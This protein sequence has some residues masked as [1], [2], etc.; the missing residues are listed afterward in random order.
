MLKLS[1]EI[2]TFHGAFDG[3]EGQEIARL[4]LDVAAW[5]DAQPSPI[6]T[7]HEGTLRDL[8]GNTCGKWELK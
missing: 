2:K 7:K 3:R 8:N 1:I 6:E 5:F 4:L